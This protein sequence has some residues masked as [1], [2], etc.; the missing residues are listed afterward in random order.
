MVI[1]NIFLVSA[2]KEPPSI[3]AQTQNTETKEQEIIKV[4]EQKFDLQ[5]YDPE[6]H[7]KIPITDTP[8]YHSFIFAYERMR[9][10]Q[11]VLLKEYIKNNGISVDITNSESLNREG[12]KIYGKRDYIGAIRFFREAAYLDP[13]NVYP[14][15]NLACCLSLLKSQL[16]KEYG[17]VTGT[18]SYNENNDLIKK[19]KLY[20]D[21]KNGISN[22]SFPRTMLYDELYDNLT[23]TF[24]LSKE[25]IQKSQNDSDLIFIRNQERFK[26]LIS[27]VTT[28]RINSVY[29]CWYVNL[30]QCQVIYF[31]LDQR[32][33]LKEY[34]GEYEQIGLYFANTETINA[35][36]YEEDISDF[37]GYPINFS[38]GGNK[39][40]SLFDVQ[41]NNLL[42]RACNIILESP[43]YISIESIQVYTSILPYNMNNEYELILFNDYS[44]TYRN[45]T[46][47]IKFTHPILID[48]EKNSLS[49]KNISNET[50]ESLLWVAA[51]TNNM[52]VLK[53]ILESV[54]NPKVLID[55]SSALLFAA[56]QGNKEAVNLF[57]EY[58]ADVTITFNFNGYNRSNIG[59]LRL[60]LASGNKELFY[61]LYNK[62]KDILA[63]TNEQKNNIYQGAV[64]ESKEFKQEIRELLD[65]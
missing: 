65:F 49:Q 21:D 57:I 12:Y 50:I 17:K 43:A 38:G 23:L 2:C 29:G 6:Y 45:K 61:E 30:Y 1:L 7:Y 25:H 9:E 52:N 22:E 20:F 51:I 58:G 8:E 32:L 3:Q 19:Y 42:E 14:H 53:N 27:N 40:F 35:V 39:Q 18:N 28:G 36:K 62:Y 13:T 54:N 41:D 15:Y 24:L 47:L 10:E 63:V 26:N 64:F 59:L 37:L 34:K 44:S 5:T 60:V 55:S 56:K 33:S 31:M 11:L 4:A 46:E 48:L 16:S